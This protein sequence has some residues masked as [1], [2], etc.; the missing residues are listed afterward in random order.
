MQKVREF[1]K[2]A[3]SVGLLYLR[4]YLCLKFVWRQSEF[5]F[6]EALTLVGAF[7]FYTILGGQK[8]EKNR[9]YLLDAGYCMYLQFM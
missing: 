3:N 6:L 8:D 9:A 7:L 1:D 4:V 5:A 2:S